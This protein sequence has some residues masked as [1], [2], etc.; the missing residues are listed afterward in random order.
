MQRYDPLQA[1]NQQEWLALDEDDRNELVQDYHRRAG[2]RLPRISMHAMF[3]VVVEN[4]VALGD[5]TPVARTL[6]RLMAEG[7][8]RH[9]ALHAIG[10]VLADCIH[11]AASEPARADATE[12]RRD[13]F[14][15]VEEL[16]AEDW[17]QSAAE[18]AVGEMEVTILDQLGSRDGLPVDA[19]RTARAQRAAVLP[20]FLQAIERTAEGTADD[21]QEDALFIIFHLLGEWRETSAYRPLARL[22]RQPPD[23]PERLLGDAT[24]ETGYRVM[25]A[26][27][28]GDPQP[29]YEIILDE[30]ADEFVRSCMFDTLVI[31]V[32]QGRLPRAEAARFL[33]ACLTE[34]QPRG[35]HPVWV[36]WA[37]AIAQLAL[38]E[39]KPAVDQAF[40][41]GWIAE[42]EMSFEHFED[43]LRHA[44]A[45]SEP[46]FYSNDYTM[47]GDTIEELSRWAA[48]DPERDGREED[49]DADDWQP[50]PAMAPAVNPLKN[51]GRND[52][53]PCGS[54]K[55][56]KKCCLAKAAAA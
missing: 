13:Y 15:A 28:D 17:R 6:D 55:K 41:R 14:A 25:A 22:L 24:T 4:Q 46:P 49:D 50:P 2:I 31:L 52:P 3:H 11:E 37:D 33:T 21:R 42:Y 40:K 23:L 8:D 5:E 34:L 9:D 26:V 30:S 48:F 12:A 35:A 43:E 53:C 47:F 32:R 39:L 1:P 51:V 27:F 18:P 45:G 10:S 44:I 36:G 7:L 16:T 20:I 56:F 38:A 19:I 54:G 29:L